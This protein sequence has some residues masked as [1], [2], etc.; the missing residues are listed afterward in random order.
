MS[1]NHEKFE[2]LLSE[3]SEDGQLPLAL[4]RID[5]FTFYRHPSNP[6]QYAHQSVQAAFEMYLHGMEEKQDTLL[7]TDE[8]EAK[9][10]EALSLLNGV[11]FMFRA[12]GYAARKDSNN[13]IEKWLYD[14]SKWSDSFSRGAQ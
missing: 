12:S 11:A 10:T 3:L 7:A 1:E 8:L 4:E 14:F 2:R 13:P 5:R 6:E 9:N